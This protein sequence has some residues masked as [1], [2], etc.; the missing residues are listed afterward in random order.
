L[1]TKELKVL[2]IIPAR[3]G[4]KGIPGKNIKTLNGKPLL[5]YTFDSAKESKLINRTILSSDDDA[6]IQVAKDLKLEVPFIRPSDLAS[7]QAATLPV[8]LHALEFFREKGEEFDLVC[9][10]QTTT[11]FRRT[12]LIDEAIA[13]II[14][15]EA[16]AL[17][18]VLPVPHEF[19][20]HWIFEEDQDGLLSIATGER[21]IITR[22][23]ELPTGYFRDGAIYLTKTSV[24][25]EKNSLYGDKLA[26]VQGD[27]ERYV[28]L[29][30]QKDWELAEDLVTKLYPDS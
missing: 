11:P 26:F 14:E 12:G 4:S 27:Q 6:I 21:Q 23:Q 10:L 24:L 1:N 20:P 18:S 25:L 3:G 8:I 16:D 28:N 5:A 22:R 9:L 30:T 15:T 29:D 7:D 17:V 19:N 2:A 13:R